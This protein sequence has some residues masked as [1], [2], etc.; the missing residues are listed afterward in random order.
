MLV[1]GTAV[2]GRKILV[3]GSDLTSQKSASNYFLFRLGI[4][5]HHVRPSSIATLSNKR[6]RSLISSGGNP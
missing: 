6:S 3:N 4:Y 5:G 2:L 1:V